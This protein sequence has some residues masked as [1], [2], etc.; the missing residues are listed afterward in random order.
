MPL[1]RAKHIRY[2]L[3]VACLIT[4]GAKV[5]A[6]VSTPF[7]QKYA[8]EVN[9]IDHH[10]DDSLYEK[11]KGYKLIMV[12]ERHGT[13]EPAEFVELLAKLIVKNGGQVA[14]GLEIPK[15]EMESY[16]NKGT[17]KSLKNSDFFS[18]DNADGRNAEAWYN[19][20]LS[21][22]PDTNIKI[23]YLDN[24]K[25]RIMKLRNSAMYITLMEMKNKYPN[26]TLITLSGNVHNRLS[27]FSG[28]ETMGSLCFKDTV[29]FKE[30]EI[31][32]AVHLFGG[33]TALNSSKG[34]G[35]QIETI[36]FK[37][38]VFSRSNDFEEYLLLNV[39]DYIKAYNAI[40][41]SRNITASESLEK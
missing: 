12:G 13:H 16:I 19:L 37:D 18:K 34:E 17:E 41:Y 33:G 35:L 20:I 31:I 36:P 24:L 26:H 28:I 30:G 3:F 32:S 9:P 39:Q 15:H 10:T 1:E 2:M 11:L 7:I 6:Q 5:K 14:L 21:C 38:N 23:F 25:G 40:F 8:I 22:A 4:F 27:P 29:N